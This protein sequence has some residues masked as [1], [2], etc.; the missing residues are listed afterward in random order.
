MG[1]KLLED[2]KKAKKDEFYT[3]Y[4]T[5]QDEMKYHWNNLKGK[6][7]L[8]NCNDG[9]ESNFV[10]FFRDN[11]KN[12]ELKKLIHTTYNPEGISYKYEM[13]DSDY[14]TNKLQGNGDYKSEECLKLLQEADIV[15]TNIPFSSFRTYFDI[16]MEY[17]KKFLVIGSMNA[18]KYKNVFPYFRD[19]K[20]W[21]GATMRSGDIKFYVPHDYPL[22]AI[23]CGYENGIKYIKNKGVRWF[24]N[25]DYPERYET[26]LLKEKYEPDKYKI[27]DNYDAINVNKYKE[28]PC[29]YAGV[30]GVPITIFDHHNPNQFEILGASSSWDKFAETIATKDGS[31]DAMIEGKHLYTRIF[32]RRKK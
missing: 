20:V 26:L 28:I 21:Y 10:K 22:R 4:Q 6:T 3:T 11:F 27:Y 15:V 23:G 16:L 32:I 2:A 13:T 1:N 5:V 31:R 7:I 29:D 19:N 25:L 17:N 8:C 9:L 12:L 24:T 18:C 14:V 30:M